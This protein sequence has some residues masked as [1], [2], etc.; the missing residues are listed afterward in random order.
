MEPG[1]VQGRLELLLAQLDELRERL[2]TVI[3]AAAHAEVAYETAAAKTRLNFRAHAIEQGRKVTVDE[4]NDWATL[5]CKDERLTY[6]LAAGAVTVARD[7]LKVLGHQ[8]DGARTLAADQRS[9]V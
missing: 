6:E 3:T 9:I 4:V 8:L 7:T 1:E 2:G 5:Q